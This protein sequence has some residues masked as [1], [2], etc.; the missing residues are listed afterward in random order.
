[1]F[2]AF[3]TIGTTSPYETPETERPEFSAA[4]MDSTNTHQQL[5]NGFQGLTLG[6]P[7]LSHFH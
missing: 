6:T 5:L 2:Y 4:T 7:V 3:V 1:M